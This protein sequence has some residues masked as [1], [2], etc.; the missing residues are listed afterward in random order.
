MPTKP[1][2]FTQI[3]FA[4]FYVVVSQNDGEGDSNLGH[5]R[6]FQLEGSSWM[7]LG[8]DIDGEANGDDFG[9]SVSM[10][11]DGTRVAIGAPF[12]SFMFYMH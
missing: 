12:V 5:V 4:S 2:D 1:G 11:A 8:G 3:K 7:Q 6:V 10:N 9:F